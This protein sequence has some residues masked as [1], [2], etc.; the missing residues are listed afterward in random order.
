MI[1]TYSGLLNRYLETDS[2][3]VQG[4]T[5]HFMEYLDMI[6]SLATK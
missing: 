3:D 6:I 5:D 2:D 1:L 4:Y